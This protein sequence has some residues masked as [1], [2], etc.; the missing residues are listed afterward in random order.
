MAGVLASPGGAQ[1][2]IAQWDARVSLGAGQLWQAAE[3]PGPPS[4]PRAAESLSAQ[5]EAFPRQVLSRE[6]IAAIVRCHGLRLAES[7]AAFAAARLPA[8]R[9]VVSHLRQGVLGLPLR[10]RQM[11]RE[12]P[13]PPSPE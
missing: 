7:A 3:A 1:Q 13:Q 2:L 5:I 11:L 9:V 4:V 10:L 8:D 12:A 6:G